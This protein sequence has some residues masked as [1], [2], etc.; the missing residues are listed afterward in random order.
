MKH[1][2][3]CRMFVALLTCLLGF[4]GSVQA[5]NF[6]HFSNKD[7]LSN[8]AIQSLYQ[9]EKGVVWIGSC[10]GLNLYDGSRIHLYSS[11]NQ[12]RELLLGNLINQIEGIGNGRFWVQTNY[13]LSLLDVY[14]QSSRQFPQFKDKHFMACD[15][16]R[17]LWVL[18][19]DGYLYHYNPRLNDFQR[20]ESPAFKV[21]EVLDMTVDEQNRLWVFT[22]GR[23]YRAY[24]I[25]YDQDQARLGKP[26]AI[27]LQ[28]PLQHVSSNEREAYMID[29]TGVLYE[30]G[31]ANQS[32]YYVADLAQTLG[33]R[34][35]I[36]TIIK[37][38]NDYYL[39]FKNSGLMV[40]YFHTDQKVKYTLKD[41]EIK[42]GI[43]SLMTDRYQEAVWVGTDGQGV[44]LCYNGAYT[45]HNTLLDSPRYGVNN[46]VRALYYDSRQALW[47]GTKGG[48]LLRLAHYD[49][50]TNQA[51]TV[52]RFTALNS[53]LTNNEVYCVSAGGPKRLWIGTASGIIYYTYATGRL[54]T[55]DI[56][57]HG[58]AVKYVHDIHQL[59]D[60]TLWVA[61]V[62]EGVVK[63]VLQPHPDSPVVKSVERYMPGDSNWA[64]NYF[65]TI[66]A[67]GDSVLWFGNR[68]YG[69]YRMRVSDEKMRSY[70]FDEQ[71]KN[72]TVNDVFAIYKNRQGYWLGT[73]SGLLHADA[74]M[75]QVRLLSN[76]TVHG[77]LEDK[78]GS[79]WFSTNQGLQRITPQSEVAQLFHRDNGLKVTE[80]SDGAF[81]ED[82]QTQTLFFGG[83]NGFVTIVPNSYVS[84]DYMP[85]ISLKS[86]YVFGKYHNINQ[87][88]HADD[89][90]QVLT[91]DYDQNFVQIDFMAIDYING[92]NYTYSYFLEGA[93]SHWVETSTPQAVFTNLS[94]G[95]YKLLVKYHN[96]INGQES[97]PYVLHIRVVPPWYAGPWAMAFY[98]LMAVA[99]LV[100][101][102][103]RLRAK[104]R[105]KQHRMIERMNRQKKEEIYESKLR[106][107][108]NIT[109]EFCTPLTLIYGPCE[110]ILAYSGTDAYIRRYAQMVRL[111]AEKLN[112]LILELLEFRRLE[113]GHH[114]VVVQ[115]VDVST[116]VRG[117][118]ES[119]AEMAEN[120]RTD[121]RIDVQ[122]GVEWHTDVRCLNKIV[123]NLVSNAFKYTPDAGTISVTL[124]VAQQR[125]VLT[126]SNSG[127]GIAQEDLG[128]IFDR[129]KILDS[130]EM[131]IQNSRNGL[132]LAICKSMVNLLQ[133]EIQVSSTLG[134]LTTFCVTLPLLPVS[135]ADEIEADAVRRDTTHTS[136][137][138]SPQPSDDDACPA[139]A[140]TNEPAPAWNASRQTV[141]VI[142]D[143][144][145][146]LWFVSEIFVDRYN[147]L[148][149][150]N[151]QKA[152]DA[153]AQREPHLIISD[154]MMPGIDGLTF[155]R[156]LKQNRLWSHIPLVL[157]SALHHEDDQVNGIECGADAYVTKPFNVKYL[158]KIVQRLI[159]R[160]ADLKEYYSSIFSSYTVDNGNCIS[161]E[162]KD[163]LDK[164]MQ[165]V[166]ENLADCN[167]QVESLS[168][169]MGYGT[170][171]FYRKLKSI[172][173]KSP[174]D[175]IKEYRL[176]KAQRLLF[177]KNLTI[178]QIMV[179]TG[180]SN[181]STFYKAFSQRFG[182]P[183]RQYREQLKGEV[184][185]EQPAQPEEPS[186]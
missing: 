141:M 108:T 175:L 20:I 128:K 116:L 140:A 123:N 12:T 156:T 81:F 133:G 96:H 92:S 6:R 148:S 122:P 69:A 115:P 55:L 79:I 75:E 27:S 164:M 45:L 111:N 68:G 143:D 74:G 56:R 151:A 42:S 65:F 98:L 43:F 103:Y 17:H 107:F 171:Q 53:S 84:Q 161:K 163:F 3:F 36:S 16:R 142:D 59:N 186:L 132:G 14:N 112:G 146:M 155:T 38:R 182:M 154:V 117:W 169:E 95:N 170:R 135:N 91:L 18:K 54:S 61:T 105:R 124:Q 162:D 104:Y 160:E 97:R 63:V 90:E 139:E 168:S 46:P 166:E 67:E 144:P 57:Q 78:R 22:T 131:N 19:E 87:Y 127:K 41:T 167:W 72:S 100:A 165:I 179:Q 125:L 51:Q 177:S 24:P 64:S 4:V 33:R 85:K 21:N 183:P 70:R 110:K 121:Y 134:V 129:Y 28:A 102:I 30:F 120:H 101:V 99:L 106:F 157:L 152:L 172:T 10:D 58:D 119:F 149:F 147:V 40:L 8:S 114:N 35:E 94:P 15:R 80:F 130:V 25:T 173:D 185:K 7:G 181:R 26:L 44:Y 86:L 34:G 113:T 76:N 153:L 66:F 32:H 109:H 47:V 159:Q 83:T 5:Y 71:V 178:E 145:S 88:L 89:G 49:P 150:D 176:T 62:G 23:T 9:D 48:G 184:L 13:G 31:F 137:P 126:I 73:S 136:L 39:G 77:I 180:F 118:A 52:E 93:G 2:P 60:T 138:S 1:Y 11:D 37:Q 174:A 158:E 29:S 50:A 82:E